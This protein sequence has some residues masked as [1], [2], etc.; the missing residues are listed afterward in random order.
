M[1]IT[2]GGL[3]PLT[4]GVDIYKGVDL[5]TYHQ[6]GYIPVHKYYG[7]LYKGV[8]PLAYHCRGL[9]PHTST[10]LYISPQDLYEG[11]NPVP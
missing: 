6:R 10:P 9:L 3:L 5:V 8:D 2:E 11:V 4:S 7:A 1:Y